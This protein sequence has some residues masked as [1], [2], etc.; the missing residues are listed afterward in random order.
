MHDLCRVIKY[1]LM[2]ALLLAGALPGQDVTGSIDGRVRDATGSAVSG[3]EVIAVQIETGFERKVATNADGDYAMTALGIG[4]Y[5]I[6]VTHPGFKNAV[7]KG[8]NLHIGDHLSVDI[9]LEV[10]EVSQ[11]VAVNASVSQVQTETSEQGELISGEQV[12]ELQLN[13]RSFMTLLELL[14]GV[15]SNM[16]DRADPNTNPA[17]SINGARSSA[18]T[19]SIDGGNN[20]DVIVGSGSLNT[21][22]SVETIAEFKVATSIFA[23]E[24]GR[25]GFAQ[26]NVVTRGGSK[27]FHGSLFE[28]FRNDAVDATDY[29][30]HQTL[31]LKL[32]NFG[33]VISG[34]V[35][36]RKYNRDRRK[37]FFFF[38]QEFNRI[39]TRATAVTTTVP[40]EA[41]K[42]GDFRGRG[43]GRD[44]V[45]GTADDPV[46]DPNTLA[47]FPNGIIPQSRMDPN[48]VKIL[49]LY[50][51]P[52][53]VGP[54]AINYISA[55]PSQ[56]L[57][58]EEMI[59]IDHQFAPGWKLFGR[60]AKDSAEIKN[61]YGGTSISAL[62][63]RFPG[64]SATTASRPGK[65][66][67]ANLTTVASQSTLNELTFTYAGREI[68][69]EAIA[70]TANRTKLGVNIP[71]IFP[72][73]IGNIIPAITLG[74]GFSALTVARSY[75]KQ[76]FNL[77]LSD[78]L[79]KIKGKHQFKMGGIYSYGGNRENPSSP[80]T[81]GSYTFTTG[82][83]KV[84]VA[85][86][87]LGLPF[88]YSE[89]EHLVVSNARFALFEA[90]VQDD[91]KIAPRLTLN[92]GVRYTSYFNPWDT[93]N[94]LTNFLPS[95][96][97]PARAPKIDRVTGQ[98]VPGTGDPLN[99]IIIAGK[100]SPYGRLIT[101]N[102][103]NKFG[104]RLGLSWDPLGR[105]KTVLSGGF[106]INY[107]RP[108]IGTFINDAF[109][110]PPF[111]R[112][113]TINTPQFSNPGAGVQAANS[114][115]ALTASA[116]PMAMPTILQWAVG[117]QQE[118][119]RTAL[120]KVNYVGSRGSN[121]MRPLNINDAPA[122]A[123]AAQGVNVNFLR[124]YAGYGAITQRQ[125][126]AYSIYHS[127]QV[128]FNRRFAGRY[129][130][131]A[132][133]TYAKS[134]DNSS[135]ERGA[136]DVPPNGFDPRS[137]RG[138]SDFD[139]THVLTSNFIWMVPNLVHSRAASAALNGWQFTGI[140][141]FYTGNPF[142]VQ[143]STDVAGIG[144]V[145]NQR[146]NVIA[147]TRGPRTVEQWFN[148]DAFAR[149]KNGTFG[150]MGRNSLRGP[151]I[152][153]W[154]LSLFKN[155][156]YSER[157]RVTFRSEFFN[158][159]NHPSFSAPA[160]ALNTTATSVN[161]NIN[162][163]DVIT[164]TRDARVLQFGLKVTF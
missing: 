135:S 101:N 50:P 144:A 100:N 6:S 79:T 103:T 81:N 149:P 89:A 45:F 84:S 42:R 54:G 64:I 142:D 161:P 85:N 106:G 140:L 4:S 133:Y 87:L 121:L 77:E 56:Q 19:F 75:L 138:P 97:D 63:N 26:V 127:L 22:T 119:T 2:C 128:S 72:E 86:M 107:T 43:A 120:L 48:A 68:T 10:G 74:S 66:L 21:F 108:L 15:A 9:S 118:L 83:S 143:L 164:D 159:F 112:T 31:P 35:M 88:S 69:Q 52:N 13:G 90:F 163:F 124:P 102:N 98:P 49:N 27:N 32:N 141:R 137:E 61:P 55:A 59:R 14:P 23:A 139:R 129:S 153:K 8:I 136:S 53:Y 104:P 12:R 60:F 16:P 17:L 30:S 146:P 65:N 99:G 94:V 82:F 80:T 158:A 157:V 71:E 152:N 105:R 156:Y 95:A 18:S 130:V 145:Q 122:G 70:D 150:N 51:N 114:V 38:T 92:L 132:A 44:G 25:G 20:S 151:G 110:N 57:W 47:G 160:T 134:I 78:N 7:R 34:P 28:F 113:V 148:K 155:F 131:G 62:G 33:Y 11:Q 154:D 58:R 36:F 93:D 162:N 41:E 91:W 111:S 116:A 147:D 126:T 96:F 3:A 39:S 40:T 67:T 37:T 117:V 73:N 5:Q 115:A 46:V 125:D 24:Y 29:F 123:A 1:S 109:D 76:L